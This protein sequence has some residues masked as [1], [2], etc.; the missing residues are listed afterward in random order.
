MSRNLKQAGKHRKYKTKE[1]NEY[2]KKK[3]PAFSNDKAR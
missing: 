1:K 3:T 2:K